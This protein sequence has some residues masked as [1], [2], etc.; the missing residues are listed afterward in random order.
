MRWTAHRR[1]GGGRAEV[2]LPHRRDSGMATA[3]LAVSLVGLTAALFPLVAALHLVTVQAR[4]QETAR[5]I[6]RDVARGRLDS[7]ARAV[8]AQAFPSA[9]TTIDRQGDQARVTV[10]APVR[11]GSLATVTVRASAQTAVEQP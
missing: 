7:E 8:A 11:L 5:S 2:R 4:A 10:A 6:A 3:E 9:D 1:E